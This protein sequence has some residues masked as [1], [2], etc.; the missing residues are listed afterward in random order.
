VGD[1]PTE[2]LPGEAAAKA[3]LLDD[4]AAAKAEIS[5]GTEQASPGEE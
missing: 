2:P 1:E 3:K 5:S 4:A